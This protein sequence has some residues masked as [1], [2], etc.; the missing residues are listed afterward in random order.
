MRAARASRAGACCGSRAPTRAGNCVRRVRCRPGYP[1]RTDVLQQL[2]HQCFA[3]V[4][5]AI[6]EVFEVHGF[7]P[8]RVLHMHAVLEGELLVGVRS[9]VERHR[10][11]HRLEIEMVQRV[12]E[13]GEPFA[14][15]S[16]VHD[17]LACAPSVH[18]PLLAG[19]ERLVRRNVRHEQDAACVQ[20]PF[21][22]LRVGEVQHRSGGRDVRPT[23]LLEIAGVRRLAVR[24]DAHDRF[25]RSLDHRLQLHDAFGHFR[26]H[27]AAPA[28]SRP[29]P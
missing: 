23:M 11:H 8:A 22:A 5:M 21:L 28:W 27:I 15:R 18:L 16:L 14:D 2:F 17:V 26:L 24:T 10:R 12:A 6:A 1:L 25:L 13:P 19:V 4:A 9:V 29:P 7:C 3:R 20:F